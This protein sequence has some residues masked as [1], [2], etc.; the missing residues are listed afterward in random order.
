MPKLTEVN[1]K[2]EKAVLVQRQD[3]AA[4]V[5]S[6]LRRIGLYRVIIGDQG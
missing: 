1:A 5:L 6:S 3:R 2:P 4:S